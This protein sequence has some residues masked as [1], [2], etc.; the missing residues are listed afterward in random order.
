MEP[1]LEADEP[2]G[3]RITR[4]ARG[5][6]V[7]FA[8]FVLVTAAL[9]VLAVLAGALDLV[10]WLTR[11]RPWV[12]VRLLAAVWWFLF[13]ELW[14]MAAL[15]RIGLSPIHRKPA[16]KRR[17]AMLLRQRWLIKH[18]R[19]IRAI[20]ALRFDVDGLDRAGG[21]V[22]MLMRHA[23]TVDTLLPDGVVGREHGTKFRYVLKRE[24]LTLP[25]IDVGRRW[26]PTVFVRRGAGE[27]E[28]AVERCRML[29]ADLPADEGLVI[30]PEGTLF[31]A[32]KLA[33]RQ[34]SIAARDPDLAP[35]AARLRHV[36]PPQVEGT[37]ALLRTAPGADVLVCGHI[38]LAPFEY[39]RDM[40]RGALI[41]STVQ[42]KFWRF[43]SAEV[44]RDSDATLARWIYQRWLE[45]DDW[46]ASRLQ[47][48]ATNARS[49][50]PAFPTRG[51]LW[52][53]D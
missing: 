26:V 7:E 45:L 22:V 20:F 48:P 49:A 29:A 42:V 11:R 40:W 27:A 19:G 36:L 17:R 41:G 50:V 3:A 30:Y 1:L 14:G 33:R 39:P 38:G 21:Q 46:I 43:A 28:A 51:Q 37:I 32:A 12:A 52:P 34:Q 15:L 6:G 2:L 31:S 8:V 13:V 4:R 44:P 18:L 47:P 53:A 35:L 23:S 25:T 10:R 24:L 16:A 5:I 9:P